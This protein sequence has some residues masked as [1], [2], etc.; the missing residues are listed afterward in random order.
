LVLSASAAD[1]ER[2]FKVINASNGL[3]D[4]S[5][6]QV[7]CT[8]TGRLVIAARGN[9]N[10]F[11]GVSFYHID[12]HSE[13][14]YQLPQYQGNDHIY[15][16]K[17][18]HLWLKNKYTVT[19]V[20]LLQESFVTDV[21]S[22]MRHVMGCDNQVLDLFTDS[23]GHVWLVTEKGLYGVAQ[24]KHY[25][26]L[27]ERSIQD[28]F[29][30]DSL[31]L[32]F[33][34][35]GEEVGQDVTSGR[36]VHRTKA[37]GWED[38]EKYSKSSV[39]LPF[40]DGLYQ[41]R[42]GDQES[43]L[44][45]F[46]LKTLQWSVVM[47]LP[48]HMNNMAVDRDGQMLYIVT[49]YGY[50]TYH[51]QTKELRHVEQLT[52]ASGQKQ[53]VSCNS[54]AFDRQGG[55]WIA[56]DKRGMLYARPAAARFTTYTWDQP[57]AR[58]YA[59]MMDNLS[60]NITEFNGKQANCMYTDSRGWTWFGTTKGLYMYETPQ[61]EPMVFSKT[62]GLL[63]NVIHAV[64]EDSEHNVWVSTSC[65]I[66]CILFEKGRPVFVNSFNEDD[67]VP[68]ESFS[69]NKALRLDD[70]TIVMQ[71]LDH[72][73]HFDPRDFGK[74]NKHWPMVLYPK[75]VKV[76]VNGHDVRPGEELDGNVVIDRAI[77]R[78]YDIWLNAD[79][80]TVSLTF[81]GL[82][83]LRPLQTYYRVKVTGPGIR[84]EEK[85]YSYYNGGGTVD[86]RGQFHLPLV[87]L[88]PGEY[89]VQVQVSMFPNEW[90]A[91]AVT[92]TIHVNQPWWR[93][94][95]VYMVLSL[96]LIGLLVA[97][98]YYFSQN[99]KMRARRNNQEGDTIRKIKSFV[100]TCEGF[101][102]EVLEPTP[103][104]IYGTDEGES[105]KLQPEFIEIMQKLIPFVQQHK[106]GSLSMNQ[107]SK[108][109]QVDIVELYDVISTNLYKSP[110]QLSIV[111]R[112]QDSI[113]LL[114]ETDMSIEEIAQECGFYTPN[115]YIGNFFHKYK[116]TPGEY[117]E[118]N[119][120]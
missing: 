79:Q 7:V 52:F 15:F 82:N 76:L 90:P 43:I 20:D 110:R 14:N 59:E 56:T 42:N 109:A 96:I 58:R 111:T 55:L 118:E 99:T 28:L 50:W 29:V 119:K 101:S 23:I 107:L 30:R 10:F 95:G 114:T 51:L 77:T 113:R 45:H 84:D 112:L 64:V 54:V 117:R 81:T 67:N 68:N 94:T 2:V 85:V 83:Y 47:H 12:T 35:N 18:H 17:L 103:D 89:T 21:D 25:P 9:L 100:D 40:G 70:G 48:Y 108:A 5:A 49:S 13:Y 46:D 57:E 26:M 66:S 97:N 8:L 75:M 102:K 4:N 69:N 93:T 63:N 116:M 78:A 34:D 16:D 73:V 6:Q 115:Y 104:E 71:A 41:I 88:K 98:F 91:K 3:S 62:N 65:G 33:Y 39:L 92:W 53:L 44:L 80:N 22:V 19:C 24:K 60:Q 72:V 1:E 36:T 105:R 74:V 87:S 106:N 37:Y 11:N 61:S 120:A 32:T 38:G 31:L 27:R 86:S